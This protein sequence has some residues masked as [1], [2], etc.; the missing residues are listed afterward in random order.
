MTIGE[1]I[2]QTDRDTYYKLIN[3]FKV[4]ES[5]KK[6]KLGDSIENLMKSDS[7]TRRGRRLKQR[8]WGQ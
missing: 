2:K 7:Y 3:M 1:Y 8:S 6:I 4:K 5:K